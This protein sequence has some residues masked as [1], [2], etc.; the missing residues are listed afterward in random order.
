MMTMMS[1]ELSLI[2]SAI[3]IYPI[4]LDLSKPPKLLPK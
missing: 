3:S 1:A 2:P 4:F